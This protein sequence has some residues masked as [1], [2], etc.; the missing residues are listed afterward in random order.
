[1]YPLALGA[2][3]R[4]SAAAGEGGFGAAQESNLPTVG[5]QRRTG[6]EAHARMAQPCRFARV[7]ESVRE[8]DPGI[9]RA[10]AD[11]VSIARG[12]FAP[13]RWVTGRFNRWTKKRGADRNALVCEGS[14][15]LT[16]SRDAPEMATWPARPY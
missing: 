3:P 8:S 15:L 2:M 14:D 6:F 9:L 1:M 4:R 5:L 12:A 10:A 16:V 11:P 13:F 7:R